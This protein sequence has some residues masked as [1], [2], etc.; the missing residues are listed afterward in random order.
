MF[1]R[2]LRIFYIVMIVVLYTIYSE[3]MDEEPSDS[4]AIHRKALIESYE[5]FPRRGET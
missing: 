3:V 4:H 2:T 1:I 5:G